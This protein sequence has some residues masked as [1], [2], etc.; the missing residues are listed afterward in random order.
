MR[1]DI[2]S[3]FGV[4]L[5][6][7][8]LSLQAQ[9]L[10]TTNSSVTKE[11]DNVVVRFDTELDEL[12]NNYR[13]VV[14]PKIFNLNDTISLRSVIFAGRVQRIKDSRADYGYGDAVMVDKSNQVSYEYSIPFEKWMANSSLELSKQL[15]VCG[16]EQLGTEA[17]SSDN[18]Q[19]VIPVIES[20]AFAANPIE[21]HLG[22]IN[23]RIM[24]HFPFAQPDGSGEPNQGGLRVAYV[25]GTSSI[26]LDFAN[27]RENV[28]KMREGLNSLREEFGA[29]ISN[30]TIK[31]TSSIDGS[32]KLN[33]RLSQRRAEALVREFSEID[34]DIFKIYSVGE[35]WD[36]LIDS[37][38]ASDIQ[39]KDEAL[40]IIAKYGIMEGREKKLM[41]LRGGRVYRQLQKDYFAEMR[42][43]SYINI[44]YD[45]DAPE[46][47]KQE[48]QASDLIANGEY[49]QAL[50]LLSTMDDTP[51][52]SNMKGVCF[53][54][55]G[56][57]EKARESLQLAIEGGNKDALTNLQKLEDQ[58]NQIDY[59]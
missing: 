34:K 47:V 58:Q 4:A 20:P 59:K 43:A 6:L 30:I 21:D 5:L 48:Q 12:P 24:S 36:A 56:E 54:M 13:V 57:V 44:Y 46:S 39:Y 51:S 16:K 11:G 41:D 45:L 52:R 10:T 3:I 18:L 50:E 28:E 19:P 1:K 26:D 14:T 27:N 38:K 42:S 25:I 40:D 23:A 29:T 15:G 33:Q 7:N 32:Y 2:L 22:E 8:S 37:I 55:L 53:M 35:D 31:G 17:L 9:E 49:T